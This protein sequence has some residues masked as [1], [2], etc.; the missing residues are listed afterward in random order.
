VS[1]AYFV[2]VFVLAAII[3]FLFAAVVIA[4]VLGKAFISDRCIRATT[5]C[6]QGFYYPSP[7]AVAGEIAVT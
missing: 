5:W 4:I 6:A 3:V 1:H 2:F 7:S